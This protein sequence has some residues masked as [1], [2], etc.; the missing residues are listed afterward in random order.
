MLIRELTDVWCEVN[1]LRG[2]GA[3]NELCVLMKE[4]HSF[5]ELSNAQFNLIQKLH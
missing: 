1:I 3:V 4:F 5:T 2:N